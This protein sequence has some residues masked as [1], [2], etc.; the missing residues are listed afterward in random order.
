MNLFRILLTLLSI[1]VVFSGKVDWKGGI[2]PDVA[3]L[4]Q[5]QSTVTR[6]QQRERAP[7]PQDSMPEIHP[8]VIQ[9]EIYAK[10]LH[11]PELLPPAS[12]PSRTAVERRAPSSATI[13][14]KP[15]KTSPA[16]KVHATSVFAK[17]PN[18]SMALISQPGKGPS[19]IRP[20]D[21]LGY[22][23]VTKIRKDAVVYIFEDTTGEVAWEPSAG[24]VPIWPTPPE[25][26]LAMNMPSAAALSTLPPVAASPLP[27][28]L[29]SPG[30]KRMHVISPRPARGGR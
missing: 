23:K 14:P 21:I 11:P 1:A 30:N 4:L 10:L 16:F 9:A 5:R 8:L 19:W 3:V 24:F 27:S 26:A 13:P 6:W 17:T 28:P 15:P 18:K 20:G 12:K 29:A 25:S 22:L 7:D 2:D